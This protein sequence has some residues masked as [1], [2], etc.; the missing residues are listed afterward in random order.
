MPPP[1]SPMLHPHK[2][3]P[4]LMRLG[5]T[6]PSQIILFLQTHFQQTGQNKDE[7]AI[8]ERITHDLL[9]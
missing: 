8:N 9:C 3:Q 7:R 1:S 5:L 4:H 2:I 6:E